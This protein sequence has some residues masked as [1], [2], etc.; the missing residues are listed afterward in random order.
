MLRTVRDLFG[1]NVDRMVIDDRGVFQQVRTFMAELMPELKERVHLY[2]GAEPVFDVFGVEA[3]LQRSLGRKVWLKSGGYLVIDQ[4]EALMAIDVNSGRFVGTSSLEETTLRINLE[5]VEEVADQIRLR[6]MGGIIIIDFIDME[7]ESSRQAVSRALEE[8]L[9][10]DRARTNVLG[11]SEL[12]LVEM[13]R[14]RVQEGLDRYLYEECPTCKGGAVVK[15]KSTV[16]FEI[17]R[18]VRREAARHPD[19]RRVLVSCAPGVADEMYNGHV[20]DLVG[21]E[22]ALGRSVVIRPVATFHPEQFSVEPG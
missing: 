13:T 18:E 12:G 3:S 19:G 2:R 20:E 1:E 9:K 11:I 7:K 16:C 15:A 4:T 17:L 22:D 5:A 6:N 8:A 21:V 10:R 14:K